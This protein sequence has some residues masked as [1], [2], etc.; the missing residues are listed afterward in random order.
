MQPPA[1][2][3]VAA[4]AAG[5]G[6]SIV[7]VDARD[8]TTATESLDLRLSGCDGALFGHISDASGGPIPSARVCLAPPRASACV[9]ADAAGAYTICLSPRQDLVF[10]AAP[11]YGAIE[12][13]LDFKARRV[14]RD[15]SLTPEATIVGHVVRAEDG[16]PVAGATVQIGPTYRGQRFAAPA[17]TISD[18]RGRF[19][20][21]GLAS[22][23]Q[24]LVAVAGDL[25][26]T[27]EIDVNVEAGRQSSEIVLRLSATSR[28]SRVSGVVTDGAKPI[29]G[30][31]IRMFPAMDR[32]AVTQSDGTFVLDAAP[33]G[34]A[35]ISVS[36]YEVKEPRRLVID[37]PEVAGVRVVV[38]A[39]GS[40][41]GRVTRGGKLLAGARVTC[42]DRL[43]PTYT[44]DDGTYVIRGLPP[45]RYSVGAYSPSLDAFGG[46]DEITLG[47]G[48]HRTR[49]DVD[50]RDAGSIAGV[51]TE[52]DGTPVA[53]ALIEFNALKQA[54]G[55]DDVTAPDGTFRVQGLKGSDDYRPVLRLGPRVRTLIRS[56]PGGFPTIHLED[57]STEVSG[58]H[59]VVNRDHLTISGTIVDADSQAVSDVHVVALRTDEDN[60]AANTSFVDHPNAISAVD[61]GFVI[62]DLDAGVFVLQAQAGDGSDATVQ[63]VP[64]GQKNVVVTLRRA[65]GIEGVLEGFAS[66]PYVTAARQLSGAVAPFV[67]ATLDGNAFR[68]RGLS[69]G[70]YQVTA[71]GGGFDAQIVEVR[72]GP[73][74]NV[75]L[76][77]RGLTTIRGRV[78][79]WRS[80]AAVPGMHCFPGVRSGGLTP[81][82]ADEVSDDSDEDGRFVLDQAPA[83]DV[84]VWCSGSGP[85]FSPGIAQLSA[86]AGQDA[87][88]EV[89]VVKVLDDVPSASIGLGFQPFVLPSRVTSVVPRGPADRAG[90][91]IGDVVSTV[92]GAPVARL[93]WLGLQVFIRQ[94]PAGTTVQLGLQRGGEL[95]KADVVLAPSGN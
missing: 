95:V 64:A 25:A 74:A 75:T 29:A 66:P 77:N 48:E 10:V 18:A 84:S 85:A 22:G 72:P 76:R 65:S 88:C 53:G 39:M 67:R 60:P 24:R 63:N 12:D 56:A 87:P 35:R 82:W 23:P 14:Q 58:V 46:A 52:R 50:V 37:E 54:E 94:R 93:A 51:V 81:A 33:R 28:V 30:A 57:G 34:T 27:E 80:G 91:R 79:E 17:V 7:E 8:P 61:G 70:T 45:D 9:A 36:D 89:S 15:Y 38:A 32:D 40:I 49:V 55:G 43:P 19:S 5:H 69:P 3:S 42:S 73:V 1:K 90:V 13:R 78:V 26:S 6:P 41:A 62:R 44:A 92:D 68:F 31:L 20:I 11:G 2:F 83:G 16:A 21:T 59:V 86:P 4:T 47:R 71:G